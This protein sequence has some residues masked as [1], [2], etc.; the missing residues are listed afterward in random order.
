MTFARHNNLSV[1]SGVNNVISVIVMPCS[2][3]YTTSGDLAALVS[4]Y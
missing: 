4:R 2:G 1:Y 3:Q